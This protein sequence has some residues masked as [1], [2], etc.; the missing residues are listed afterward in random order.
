MQQ[1]GQISK[2]LCWVK[3]VAYYVIQFIWNSKRG[4][5]NLC[6][7]KQINDCLGWEWGKEKDGLQRDTKNFSWMEKFHILIVVVAMGVCICQK[8]STCYT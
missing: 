7:K 6:D 5:S 3:D 4:K 1:C 2:A 8:S